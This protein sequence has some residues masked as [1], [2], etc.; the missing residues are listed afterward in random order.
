MSLFVT[1]IAA[2]LNLR[3]TAVTKLQHLDKI[4]CMGQIVSGSRTAQNICELV[5]DTSIYMHMDIM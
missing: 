1:I 5:P 4:L 3:V 2:T